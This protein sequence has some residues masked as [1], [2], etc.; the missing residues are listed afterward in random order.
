V[1]LKDARAR[2]QSQIKGLDLTIEDVYVFQ[3]IC[4]YEVCKVTVTFSFKSLDNCVDRRTWLFE[5]LWTIY[6]GGVERV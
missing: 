2:L 5:V 3:Q 4:A 6:G 1:Y